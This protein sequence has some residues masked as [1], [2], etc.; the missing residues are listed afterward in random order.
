M[1]TVQPAEPAAEAFERALAEERLR[2]TRQLSAFRFQGVTAF[3]ALMMLFRLAVT[4]W[5]PP[6]LGL[7]AG[8]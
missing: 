2:S 4:D 6:P 5:V 8:Y 7:F 1:A 3:L